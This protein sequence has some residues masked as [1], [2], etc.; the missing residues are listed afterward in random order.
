MSVIKNEVP[1]EEGTLNTV[2]NDKKSRNCN[3]KK[4][5]CLKLYCDCFAAG[6]FCGSECNC[7]EC[8]NTVSNKEARGKIIKIIVE[9]NAFNTADAQR[10]V[11]TTLL[12]LKD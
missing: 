4:T 9:K 7:C 12:S 2:S 8:S 5:R 11:S 3:C 10:D 1:N 6:E